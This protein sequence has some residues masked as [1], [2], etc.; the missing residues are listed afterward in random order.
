MKFGELPI[1]E[2]IGGILAHSL[3][4]DGGKRLRKGLTITSQ[5]VKLMRQTG[6][7]SVVVAMPGTEDVLEDDAAAYIAD[8]FTVSG[9]RI[10]EARTGRVNLYSNT[11]GVFRVNKE[12]VDALNHIDPGVAFSTLNDLAEVNEGRLIATVK[13]IPYALPKSSLE[14]IKALDLS[15]A[16]SVIPYQQKRIGLV[17]TEI[18]TTKPSVLDKTRKILE[19]RLALSGSSIIQECR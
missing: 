19:R 4:L 7:K 2:A 18:G 13:I 12:L 8:Q 16:I 15:E 3:A 1:D 11:N 6:L 10:E 14:K 17:F 5:E 9:F